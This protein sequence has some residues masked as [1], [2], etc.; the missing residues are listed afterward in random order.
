MGSPR[1]VP[2]A[3]IWRAVMLAG[4]TCPLCQAASIRF[5]CEGPCGAVRALALPFVFTAVPTMSARGC[6]RASAAPTLGWDLNVRCLEVGAAACRVGDPPCLG[7]GPLGKEVLLARGVG[8]VMGG[9]GGLAGMESGLK[10]ARTMLWQAS[11]LTYPSAEASMVLQRPS[12]AIMPP[13]WSIIVDSGTRQSRTPATI[14]PSA[15]PSLLGQTKRVTSCHVPVILGPCRA[16]KK[17]C[18]LF[19]VWRQQGCDCDLLGAVEGQSNPK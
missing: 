17:A 2:L 19:G 11:A 8:W 3:C 18:Q 13:C 9:L 4:A 16:C 1:G 12:D 10:A 5:C 14:A 15:A 7:G 6:T